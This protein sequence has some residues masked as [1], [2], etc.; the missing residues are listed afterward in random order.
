MNGLI[1]W[2]RPPTAWRVTQVAVAAVVVCGLAASPA[3]AQCSIAPG[4]DIFQTPGPTGGGGGGGGATYDEL[5]LPSDFF[6]PGSDPFDGVVYFKGQPFWV[7][8]P[9]GFETADTIVERLTTANLP[10][11]LGSQD[12]VDTQMVALSLVS[13]DPIT[14]TFNG[15]VDMATYDVQ[16]C[17]SSMT[18]Q[19]LGWMT[20]RHLCPNGGTFDSFT[21]VIPRL[22]FTWMGGYMGDPNPIMD[23]APQLDF[24][25]YSGC[26][27][28]TAP[29]EYGIFTTTGGYADHD[30]DGTA[31][32]YFPA[33]TTI[34]YEFYIGVCWL[35]CDGTGT[36]EEE[37]KKRM[38]LEEQNWASHGVLP[39]EEEGSDEDGDGT[40]DSADNC[41]WIPNPD[42]SDTD[43]CVGGDNPGDPC[44]KHSDCPGGYCAGDT[45]GD[46][47]DNC[48]D[49]IN[50]G[51]EDADSDGIGDVCD[52]EEELASKWTQL[53]HL[54][55]EGFDAASD[56]WWNESPEV[57]VKY[58]QPPD[59]A[60]GVYYGWDEE[61]AWWV[62]PGQL[63]A[64]DWPC[65]DDRPI[66]DVHWWGSYLFWDDMTPPDQTPDQF[67]IGIWTDVP[68]GVDQ[69]WSHPGV[70]LWEYWA[71]YADVVET[72]DRPDYHDE[73]YP[74]SCFHYDLDLPQWY[75][76]SQ[77]PQSN[78][79]YWLSIAAHYQDGPPCACNGDLNQ[80]TMITTPDVAV[81]SAHV[82]CAVGAGDPVCDRCD[83][84]C[85]GVVG[86][87]DVAALACLMG[88]WPPDPTCCTHSPYGT[89]NPWG[90]KTRPNM[91]MDDAVRVNEPS[92][93][94]PGMIFNVGSPI[95]DQEGYSYDATFELTSREEEVNRVVADDF[96]SDGRPIEALRWWGSYLDPVYEP[97]GAGG[98]STL[99]EAFTIP[100]PS[101][102]CVNTGF[103]VLAQSFVPSQDF[104]LCKVDVWLKDGGGSDVTLY[105]QDDPT[106]TPGTIYTQLTRVVGDTEQMYTFDVPDVTLL[107]GN[108]YY[109][110]VGPGCMWCKFQ[111]ASGSDPYP[112]G[113]AY[114][115]GQAIDPL[116]PGTHTD[117]MFATYSPGQSGEPYVVDG[118]FLS[119]HH[120]EPAQLAPGCPPMVDVGDDPTVLGVYFAPADAVVW[121]GH[122]LHGLPGAQRVR[123]LR[124]L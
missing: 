11:P 15:G 93:P 66:S 13:I 102:W 100:G 4:S 89:G 39:A 77:E 23:P 1:S 112:G 118:W 121:G 32:K 18:P 90:W 53:P 25:A 48:P 108:E 12:T 91:F 109:I 10:N 107:G 20:I 33:S 95:E 81:L 73:H 56:L 55:D 36:P 44:D 45:V 47:C 98:C 54:G 40:H 122:G 50:P 64:D 34:P 94:T 79:I 113:Q 27:S 38:T 80:D 88:T 65:E 111:D 119:F 6:G 110:R 2:A 106:D 46:V 16:V 31:D 37:H 67:H 68:A 28:H 104:T 123:I 7:P 105:V 29:F 52:F 9:W 43:E 72:Y 74:D 76:F 49:D 99:E 14:V 84:D 59:D 71:D 42:Q 8:G 22:I 19:P 17:L 62:P 120:A 35:P 78:S 82:G 51:Q 117:H 114:E 61:S 115:D 124:G 69:P 5:S 103:Y 3:L 30:C 96:F 86:V 75:W 70:L 60:G 26:W 85:D 116:F 41:P 58:S 101:Y 63:V 92:D 87:S 24:L 21:P 83:I 57:S 97:D